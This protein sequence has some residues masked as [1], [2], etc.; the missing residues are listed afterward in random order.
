MKVTETRL[1]GVVLIEPKVHE[2]ARGFFLETFQRQRY[3]EALGRSLDFVQDNHSRSRK[4]VL[5]GL[6]TQR[7][8]PQDKLLRAVRGAVFDVA[9]DIDPDSPTFG[10]YASA[11]LTEDN[12]HQLFVPAGYAHGF[13]VLSEVADLEYKCIGYYRPEDESGLIWND[14]EVAI[15]WPLR[16]P[17]LSE[18]DQ[19]LPTLAEIREAATTA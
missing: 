13:Q 1:P 12:K 10:Q 2:D 3:E 11:L 17:I 4:G 18:K 14:P 5:R 9:V 8:H 7:R 19:R 15:D 16:E 6:H